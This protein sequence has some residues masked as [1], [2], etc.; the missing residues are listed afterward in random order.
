MLRLYR[1]N[2]RNARRNEYR[3]RFYP[4]LDGQF[5]RKN[6]IALKPYLYLIL[7]KS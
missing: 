6:V 5:S 7:I 2:K 1:I 4:N 3:H